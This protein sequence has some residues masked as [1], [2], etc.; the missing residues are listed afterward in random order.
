MKEYRFD[1]IEALTELV[2]EEFGSWSKEVEVTQELIDDFARISGDDYWIHTDPERCKT[3]SPFGCTIAHGF[4]TLVLISRM[5]SPPGY[6]I[7]G[8]NNMLNYGS[9][10][11]RFTGAVPVNSRIHAR[12]RVVSVEK[13]PKGTRMVREINVHVV[14]QQRPA[15]VYE[16]TMIYM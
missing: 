5:S 2:S 9:D 14:G 10:K 13:T 16:L 7:V 11:L 8:F 1:D 12:N 3:E 4:L 15:L 6:E